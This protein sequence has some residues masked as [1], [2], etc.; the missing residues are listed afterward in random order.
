MG[1]IM[2]WDE[3]IA[4]LEGEWNSDI[5]SDKLTHL[6]L[7]PSTIPNYLLSCLTTRLG[8]DTSGKPEEGNFID[9]SLHVGCVAAALGSKVDGYPFRLAV[10]RVQI[11]T[12][13]VKKILC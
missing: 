7:N 8:L 11:Q 10:E 12:S 13:R 9:P 6:K 3:I 4:R 2:E 5:C 1:M